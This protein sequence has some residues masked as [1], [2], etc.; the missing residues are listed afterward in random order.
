MSYVQS[1]LDNPDIQRRR[2]ERQVR[3][4]GSS[5]YSSEQIAELRRLSSEVKSLEG[6]ILNCLRDIQLIN[7]LVAQEER[8]A[9]IGAVMDAALPKFNDACAGLHQA[10]LELQSIASEHGI[11]V[12]TQALKIPTEAVFN[13]GENSPY[14]RPASVTL[15]FERQ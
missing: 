14:G 8:K 6:K 5:E 3:G 7:Q 9:Q 10:W 2:L 1:L 4:E 11:R 15:L 13:P 12:N